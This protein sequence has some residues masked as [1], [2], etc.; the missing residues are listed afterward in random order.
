M[1]I[2]GCPP[3]RLP[4]WLLR[5][6]AF[7][8]ARDNFSLS[9]ISIFHIFTQCHGAP[10]NGCRMMLPV[11]G[12]RGTM[13]EAGGMRQRATPPSFSLCAHLSRCSFLF[14]FFSCS[15]FV[16]RVRLASGDSGVCSECFW[17]IS[18]SLYGNKCQSSVSPKLLTR[19]GKLIFFDARMV[20]GF[21]GSGA[22]MPA[23]WL[24]ASWIP[25][26]SFGDKRV[27]LAQG[28]HI[29]D[30]GWN[31]WSVGGA[32]KPIVSR[33]CPQNGIPAHQ[34]HRKDVAV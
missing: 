29:S 5:E 31:G 17:R 34:Q 20:R 23:R 28:W 8:C 27:S 7:Y 13:D 10:Q 4:F 16:A 14:F 1:Y 6:I 9:G 18:C 15:P 33:L 24:G 25:S 19:Q 11:R 3:S 32:S 30:G 22:S 21:S 2:R 12:H 26:G